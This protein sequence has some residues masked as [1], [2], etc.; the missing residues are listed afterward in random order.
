M[1]VILDVLHYQKK[2]GCSG[3]LDGPYW[4]AG[5][6][7]TEISCRMVAL[8]LDSSSMPVRS[9]LSPCL[10]I[11]S[12]CSDDSFAKLCRSSR[13]FSPTSRDRSHG[14]AVPSNFKRKFVSRN[15]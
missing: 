2:G 12:F 3:C 15:P 6:S 13:T 1:Y 9:S 14:S 7:V 8:S 10:P 11:S 5:G 4:E